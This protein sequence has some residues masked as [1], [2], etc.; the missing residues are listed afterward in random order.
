MGFSY[1]TNKSQLLQVGC[2]MLKFCPLLFFALF[3]NH[4]ASLVHLFPDLAFLS[5]CLCSC[6]YPRPECM[7]HF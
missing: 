5:P 3:E 2:R 4:P 1:S 7:S 6:C